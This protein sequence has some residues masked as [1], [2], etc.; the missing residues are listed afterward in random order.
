MGKAFCFFAIMS[1]ENR[2]T[3]YSLAVAVVLLLVGMAA[4]L[5]VTDNRYQLFRDEAAD[6]RRRLTNQTLQ[7]NNLRRRL[8]DCDSTANPLAT[9][10]LWPQPGRVRPDPAFPSSLTAR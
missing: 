3:V 4:L 9:D 8:A 1:P 5:R 7:L 2:A 10:T 6:L